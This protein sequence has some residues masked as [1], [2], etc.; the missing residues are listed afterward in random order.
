MRGAGANFTDASFNSCT[1][2]MNLF[3]RSSWPCIHGPNYRAQRC[4]SHRFERPA[5]RLNG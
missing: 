3:V 1:R 2:G 5:Y 4:A